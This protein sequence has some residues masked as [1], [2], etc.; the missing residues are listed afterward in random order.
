MD[1][2]GEGKD[3]LS[4]RPMIPIQVVVFEIKNSAT[5]LNLNIINL[6]RNIEWKDALC[7]LPL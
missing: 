1:Y 4:L 3:L 2:T 5:T 6:S 7:Q